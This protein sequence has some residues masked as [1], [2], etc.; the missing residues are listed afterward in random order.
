MIC[1]YVCDFYKA[2]KRQQQLF[3]SKLLGFL[4]KFETKIDRKEKLSYK[5]TRKR[6]IFLKRKNNYSQRM[7]R[8]KEEHATT[9]LGHRVCTRLVRVHLQLNR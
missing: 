1:V 4:I 3:N 2:A 5:K 9:V 6:K 8:M 7:L